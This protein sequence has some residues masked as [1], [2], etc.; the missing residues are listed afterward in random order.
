MENEVDA[1]EMMVDLWAIG[2]SLDT[3]AFKEQLPDVYA[4][5]AKLSPGHRTLRIKGE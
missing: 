3:K 5:F 2:E 4:Q 1:V